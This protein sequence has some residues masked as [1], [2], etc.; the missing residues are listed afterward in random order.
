MPLVG[1]KK[2]SSNA[3]PGCW[4]T[5]SAP[6][7]PEICASAVPASAENPAAVA[8]IATIVPRLEVYIGCPSVDVGATNDAGDGGGIPGPR[9]LALARRGRRLALVVTTIGRV[10]RCLGEPQDGIAE[11]RRGVLGDDVPDGA[12]GVC[13]SAV[14][15]SAEHLPTSRGSRL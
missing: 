2:G 14:A 1:K 9:R 6:V 8:R 3:G 5:T 10:Q 15:A 13:A 12:P 7:L 11:G 4:V